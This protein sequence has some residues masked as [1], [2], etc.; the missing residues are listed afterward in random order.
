ML[1]NELE[2]AQTLAERGDFDRA[3]IIANRH[4]QEDPED[5]T[6]MM[7]MSHIMNGV[8]KPIM[9]YHI[10]K[11]C[12]QVQPKEPGG[13][14]NLAMACKDMRLGEAALRYNKRGL[15][16]SRCPNQRSMLHVNAASVLVDMGRYDEAEKHCLEALKLTPDS[17]KA[18]SNLGFCQLAQRNWKE[19]WKNYRHCLGHEW[20]PVHKYGDEPL[21]DGKGR[22]NIVLYGEQGLGDQIAFASMIPDILSWAKD[23]DSQIIFDVSNRLET[24]LKRSFPDATIYGTQGNQELMWA[25]EHR[26]VDHSLPIGQAAEYFRLKDS[27]FPKVPYLIPDPDREIMWRALFDSKKKP[28]IGIAW[29]GGIPKTDEKN[30]RVTLEALLPLFRAVD[31]HWVSL[32]YKPA[33]KEIAKFRKDHQEVDLVEYPHGTL[34]Q[35]YE[36]TAAMVSALD[37]VVSVP[38]TI[39]HLAGAMG[40]RTIAMKSPYSCWKFNS[41]N[42]F[43]PVT[44]MI[45]NKQNWGETIRETASYLEDLC[46]EHNTGFSL[47][48]TPDSPSPITSLNTPLQETQASQLASLR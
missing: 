27:E 35:D 43:H 37:A 8:D 21:W 3:Y 48:T 2:I 41:G 5:F 30:R 12:T 18:K 26:Q 11:R 34:T 13:Y 25:K 32:Q 47:D 6:W 36:D 15:K 16:L 33:G 9:A 19:G 10:A 17:E 31:A 23:N 44:A 39:V 29:S 1:S 20:R 4:L 38:T 7:V 40:V 22:G 24:L 45:E 14:M 28:V 42:L 46:L